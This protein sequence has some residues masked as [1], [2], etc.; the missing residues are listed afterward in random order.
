[1]R[2]SERRFLASTSYWCL[3]GRQWIDSRDEA[4]DRRIDNPNDYVRLE[5]ATALTSGIRVIPVLVGAARPPNN[6]SDDPDK[7]RVYNCSD[8]TIDGHEYT[9]GWRSFPRELLNRF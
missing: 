8:I 3:I 1:M 5:I 6:M 7:V 2:R 9:K 4:R